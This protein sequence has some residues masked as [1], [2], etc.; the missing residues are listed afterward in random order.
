M[1]L[2]GRKDFCLR[3]L[4]RGRSFRLNEVDEILAVYF[5]GVEFSFL[6]YLLC[7]L[8]QSFRIHFASDNHLLTL[9]VTHYMCH[10]CSSTFKQI[11]K[12][13][14]ISPCPQVSHLELPNSSLTLRTTMSLPLLHWRRKLD[15]WQQLLWN[16]KGR[17]SSD[18]SFLWRKREA[19]SKEE[20][21]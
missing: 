19:S 10:P 3:F 11:P 7:S 2:E 21:S 16:K 12:E 15:F 9:S 8:Q 4:G 6:L 17:S 5:W 20:S 1:S 18:N 14:N 13:H